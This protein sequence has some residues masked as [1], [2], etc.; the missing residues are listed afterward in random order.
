MDKVVLFYSNV[1]L[2]FAKKT[3]EFCTDG[4]FLV[5]GSLHKN[6]YAILKSK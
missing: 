3:V 5:N 1:I 4:E 2:K 6:N